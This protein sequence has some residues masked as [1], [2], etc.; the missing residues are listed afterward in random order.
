[1][2]RVTLLLDDERLYREIKAAAAKDGRPV[3]DVI[4]EAL[5]DWLRRRTGLS[6]ADR[7]RRQAALEQLDALRA[8]QP[9]QATVEE[10]LAALRDERA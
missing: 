3:K 2:R 4:A 8:R 7:A 1:M 9:V 6:A 5:G 10:T